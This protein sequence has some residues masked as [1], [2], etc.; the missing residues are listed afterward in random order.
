MSFDVLAVIS[1][2]V[3]VFGIWHA[4]LLVIKGVIIEI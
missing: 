1:W 4:G 2:I 3:N